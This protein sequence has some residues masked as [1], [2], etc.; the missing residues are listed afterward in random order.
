MVEKV[1]IQVVMNDT[2]FTEI[3]ID[4]T[5]ELKEYK[6]SVET[7]NFIRVIFTDKERQMCSQPVATLLLHKLDK[8]NTLDS[9][10]EAVTQLSRQNAVELQAFGSF[11]EEEPEPIMLDKYAKVDEISVIENDNL[12]KKLVTDQKILE[13]GTENSVLMI[14]VSN[15]FFEML[16]KHILL[17]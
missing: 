17:M 6:N 1:A 11:D 16:K 13:L 9:V 4:E 15:P 12:A 7:D 8:T 10:D 5:P 14:T 2:D 3:H